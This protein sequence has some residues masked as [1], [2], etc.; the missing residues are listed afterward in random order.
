MNWA[1]LYKNK[2]V[3]AQEAVKA[4]QSG[5]RIF[6]TGNCSV[7][8]VVLAALVEHA[9]QVQDVEI[10]HALNFRLSRLCRP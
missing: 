2:V 9:P 10:C 7:P 3:S 8:Q 4:V 6:L 5:N 1:D